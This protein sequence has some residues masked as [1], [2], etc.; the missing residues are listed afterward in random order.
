LSYFERFQYDE[1][2]RER[3]GKS[4][5]LGVKAFFPILTRLVNWIPG[6]YLPVIDVTI[7]RR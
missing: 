3:K 4:F 1:S 2:F 7:S 5:T 6:R